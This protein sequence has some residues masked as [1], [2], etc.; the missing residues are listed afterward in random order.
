L[1]IYRYQRHTPPAETMTPPSEYHQSRPEDRVERAKPIEKRREIKPSTGGGKNLSG[2]KREFL[3]GIRESIN[4]NKRY[5][6]RAKR[7]GIEGVVRVTFDINSD[8]DVSNIRTSDAPNILKGA[9]I[10]AVKESFPV[11]IPDNGG[12]YSFPKLEGGIPF[13]V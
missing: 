13:K 12:I 5:P 8:G 1:R 3:S 10:R 6:R 11:D 9:V 2:E 4:L 7:L